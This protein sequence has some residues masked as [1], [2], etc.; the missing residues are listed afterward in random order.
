MLCLLWFD[1]E[2]R[3]RE[4]L[5]V[6]YLH[7]EFIVYFNVQ[8]IS[9]TTIMNRFQISSVDGTP[10]NSKGGVGLERVANNGEVQLNAYNL[11]TSASATG[12]TLSP[13]KNSESAAS[14]GNGVA[15]VAGTVT[16]EKE[17]MQRKFS[18]AQLTRLVNIV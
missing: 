11:I 9:S 3:E 15:A 7:K 6:I 1:R 14:G 10:T 18:I 5:V 8:R 12:S 17:V 13:P 4:L 2:E 16:N